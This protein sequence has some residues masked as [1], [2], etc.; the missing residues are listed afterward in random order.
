MSEVGDKRWTGMDVVDGRCRCHRSLEPP[1]G[2]HWLPHSDPE[3]GPDIRVVV[4]CGDEPG[5]LRMVRVP[6]GWH[7]QG[8]ATSYSDYTSPVPWSDAGRCWAGAEHPVLDASRIAELA[9]R[10]AGAA[11]R[12]TASPDFVRSTSEHWLG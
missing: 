1:S 7:R 8:A 3:P 6:G 4:L 11:I 10:R 12:P 2:Q 5:F 9:G